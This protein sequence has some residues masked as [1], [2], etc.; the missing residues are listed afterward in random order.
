[1]ASFTWPSISQTDL[2]LY[3]TFADFPALASDGALALALDTDIL[4]AYNLETNTWIQIGGPSTV[5]GIGAIDSVS[6]S[7]EW[8]SVTH[9]TPFSVR[10]SRA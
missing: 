8:P 6:P 5:L 3:P 2:T 10:E 4:Y 7:R 1:M 9:S